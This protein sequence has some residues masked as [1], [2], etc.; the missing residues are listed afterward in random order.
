MLLRVLAAGVLALSTG[1]AGDRAARAPAPAAQPAAIEYFPA[2]ANGAALLDTA[3]RRAKANGMN[4]VIV[5]GADWCHDSQALAKLLGSDAFVTELGSRYAVTLI[6]VGR[7]QTGDGQNLDLVARLGVPKLA[8]TP[9]MFVIAPDGRLLNGVKDAVSWR[10][11]D[12]RKPADVLG[13]FRKL[14]R[15]ASPRG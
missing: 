2:Q 10:N 3:L 9:A 13:W 6:D 1:Q 4:A 12:S 5:F 15:R 11:A 7:P 8:S 14:S